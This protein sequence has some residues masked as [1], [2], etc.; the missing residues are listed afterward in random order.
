M[1]QITEEQDIQDLY[2]SILAGGSW[3]AG[4]DDN[5]AAARLFLEKYR[6]S[7][8]KRYVLGCTKYARHCVETLDCDYVIDDQKTPGSFLG[9]QVVSL[10]AVPDDGLVIFCAMFQA[11]AVKKKLDCRHCRRGRQ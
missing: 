10:D 11:Q 3:S 8:G 5:S 7:N 1:T 2:Q 9:K 4:T 6:V